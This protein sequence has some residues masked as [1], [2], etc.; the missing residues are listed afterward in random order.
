MVDLNFLSLGSTGNI[1]SALI[2]GPDKSSISDIT[3]LYSTGSFKLKITIPA[4]Y[5]FVSPQVEFVTSIYHPNI[6]IKGRICLDLLK[7]PSPGSWIAVDRV[8]L[9]TARRDASYTLTSEED[10]VR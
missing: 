1:L 7:S 10:S 3:C 9:N 8:F 5:P 6:Y 2:Q 4:R